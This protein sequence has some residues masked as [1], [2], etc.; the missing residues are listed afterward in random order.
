MKT[1]LK[2][3]IDTEGVRKK[4]EG[5][6]ARGGSKKTKKEKKKKDEAEVMKSANLLLKTSL[7]SAKQSLHTSIV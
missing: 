1:H 4:E 2:S 5:S 7:A 6:L 3:V